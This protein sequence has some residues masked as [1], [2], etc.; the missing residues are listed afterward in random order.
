MLILNVEVAAKLSTCKYTEGCFNNG[1][2]VVSFKI[3]C[4]SKFPFEYK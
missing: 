3:A 1:H 2:L 4:G